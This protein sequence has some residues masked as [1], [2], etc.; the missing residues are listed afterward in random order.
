MSKEILRLSSP[1]KVNGEVIKELCYDVQNLTVL[2]IMTAGRNKARAFGNMDVSQK[3]AEL[4]TELHFFVGMQAI[5][6]QNPSI[7]VSDLNNLS[8]SDAYKLMQIGR[9]FF[10]AD[11]SGED[12]RTSEEQSA[13]TQEDTIAP[14]SKSKE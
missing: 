8:G 1:I 3:V 14:N 6:K 5:I 12:L 7:D 10:K 9:S 4:D 11:F 13:P 2:D